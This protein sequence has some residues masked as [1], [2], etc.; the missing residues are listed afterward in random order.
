MRL[1]ERLS[2]VLP[3]VLAIA[4]SGAGAQ[5]LPPSRSAAPVLERAAPGALEILQPIQPG[6]WLIRQREPFHLQPV[7]NVLVIEQAR[8]LVLIDGG[9]SPGSSRRIAALIKSV[10]RKP[11]SAIAITHW[12]GDH[13][14][15]VA[16]LLRQWPEARVIATRATREHLLGPSMERYPK[17]TP[18]QVKT[19]AFLKAIAPTIAGFEKAAGDRA[20]SRRVQAGYASSLGDLALYRND[21]DGVFLPARIEAFDRELLLPDPRHPVRL[22]FLGRGNTDGDLV[23]WLPRQRILETGDLVVAPIPFG[24]GSYPGSWQ[25]VLTELIAMRPRVIVPGHGAPMHDT[26]YVRQ[27]RDML[28][29]LRTRMAVLGPSEN[30][31]QASSDIAATYAPF[32]TRFT[33]GDPWLALWFGK[34]WRKP[35]SEMLWKESRGIPIEQGKG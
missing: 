12:H 18:D 17:G 22:R 6:I 35:M 5:A 31:D 10:S 14:L 9:G 7:G 27:L 11:V 8:G 30:L 21:I 24:F 23:A 13:S 32:E 29:A 25:R 1:T 20:L 33:G 16:T 26:R 4:A 2:K 19:E 3:V 34:Y 28:A 15:G